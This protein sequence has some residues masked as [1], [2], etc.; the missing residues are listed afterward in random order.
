MDTAYYT[1]ICPNCSKE[2]SVPETQ[3]GQNLT[4]P[5]CAHE[6]YATPPELTTEQSVE[7]AK[8]VFLLPEKLPFFK[9]GRRK[10]LETRFDQLIALGSIDKY[11]EDELNILAIRLGLRQDDVYEINREHFIR[12]F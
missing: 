1:Y 5:T 2:C 7:P 4:C 11:G 9:S 3:A 10:I 12:E 8:P 6:F